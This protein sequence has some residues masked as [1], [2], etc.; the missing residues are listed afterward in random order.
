MRN[1]GLGVGLFSVATMVSTSLWYAN[2]PGSPLGQPTYATASAKEA[3][4]NE[5][6]FI[7]Q[8]KASLNKGNPR[9]PV[10]S[11]GLLVRA[12]HGSLYGINQEFIKKTCSDF[13][14]RSP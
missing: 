8:I 12:A 14:Q 5:A 10:D 7:K 3:G 6:D 4:I 1:L 13:V 11:R 2:A 9:P